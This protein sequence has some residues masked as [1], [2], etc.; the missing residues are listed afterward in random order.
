[1]PRRSYKKREINPDPVYNSK[2]VAKLIN[3]I[4]KDGKKSVA[5][6]IV[7]SAFDKIKAKKLDPIE[8]LDKAIENTAPEMEVRARR[9]GGA[10]YLVP[11]P[12]RP[13]RKIFLSLNW[14]IEAASKKS[15]KQFKNFTE[16]LTDEL[17]LAA[18]GEGGAV[19]K[20]Q[21]VEKL[22]EAN[23]AFAHLRW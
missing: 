20:R 19:E 6:R 21:E 4:M 16:K 8:I 22:V 12:V 11:L 15:S 14:I 5:E 23:K 18:K 10:S 1:M 3:Y 7:Y 2:T 13:N 9:L 17:L